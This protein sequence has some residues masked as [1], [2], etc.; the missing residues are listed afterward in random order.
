MS[1]VNQYEIDLRGNKIA[2]I[3]NLGATENQFDSLDLSDNAIVKVEGFPR[4]LR[5]KQLLLNNNRVSKIERK[6]EDSIPN[7]EALIL[8]NNKL[9]NLQDLDPLASLPYLKM[10]SLIGNPVALKPNYRLYVISKCKALKVL[11]FRKVNQKER[12]EAHKKFPTDEA[13]AQHG[14]NTF[15]PEED[16]A[17]AQAQA[18]LPSGA[19]DADGEDAEMGEASASGKSA[20]AVGAGAK[21][22]G[23][24]PTPQQMV[25]LQ[26]AIANAATLEE[27]HRLEAALASGQLPSEFR[28]AEEQTATGEGKPEGME[29]G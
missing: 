29:V 17:A 23:G 5:L 22:G 16:L 25:A 27:I 19:A 1:C 21:K 14:A 13:A 4:L 6:L 24:A 11:D 2:T 3:E 18:G 8:T 9:T 10:I 12:E 15:E 7:L 28:G 26:A 20:S